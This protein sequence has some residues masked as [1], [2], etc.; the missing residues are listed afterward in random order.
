MCTLQNNKLAE[1]Y[2]RR[3]LFKTSGYSRFAYNHPVSVE[4]TL[5][6]YVECPSSNHWLENYFLSWKSVRDVHQ[7]E[8]THGIDTLELPVR[9]NISMLERD[10]H[11]SAVCT[12]LGLR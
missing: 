12:V 7:S 3:Q 10:Q 11:W 4:F 5:C 6:T 1:D 8:I 9:L 2:T